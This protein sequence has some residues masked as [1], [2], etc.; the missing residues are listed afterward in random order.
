MHKKLILLIIVFIIMAIF[1]PALS[2][3]PETIA[4]NNLAAGLLHPLSGWD[5]L[6]ALL[7]GA[8]IFKTHWRSNLKTITESLFAGFLLLY[9]FAHGFSAPAVV[10][11]DFFTGLVIST[12]VLQAVCIIAVHYY[13]RLAASYIPLCKSR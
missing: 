2:A 10:S 8:F 12:T 6:L 11:M 5:H 4:N 9:G 7:V 3:H 1:A 13:H